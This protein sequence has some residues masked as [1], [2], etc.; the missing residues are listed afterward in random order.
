M[1]RSRRR[2][3]A[4]GLGLLA[5]VA[6]SAQAQVVISQVYGGG[7]NSNAAYRADYIEL[8]NVTSS[9]QSVAGWS[10]QYASASGTSWQVTPLSGTI[11]AGGYLLV[12]QFDNTATN[13]GAPVAVFDVAGS[14]NM[15]GTSG[16]VAL[17]NSTAPLSGA[18]P[19]GRADLV[20]FGTTTCFEG[21]GAAPSPASNAQAVKRVDDCVDT[22][23][24]STDFSAAP[25][26]P[27]SSAS[28]ISSC[29]GPV[30]PSLS[31]TDAS[32]TEGDAGTTLATFTIAL[33]APAGAGGV[34]FDWSTADGTAT[35]ADGDYLATGGSLVIPAGADRVDVQVAISGDT[36]SEPNE[37]FFVNVVN[38][39]GATVID[40]QGAGTIVNDDFVVLPIGQV[41]GAGA[42]S[43]YAGQ[44]VAVRGIV[45]GRT[46]RGFFLQSRD[47]DAD[48]DPT[49]S[50]GAY[51]F[52]NAAPPAIAQPGRWLTVEATVQEYVPSTDPGQAPLTE[53]VNATSIL[54]VDGVT[55][56][57]PAPVDL[58]PSFPSP[59]GALD[60]LERLEG[61]R[62][63]VPD[64]VATAPSDGFKTESSAT[65]STN[66]QFFGTVYGVARP[67]REPGIQAPDAPPAGTVPPIPRWDS[68][69]EVFSVDSDGLVNTPAIDVASGARIADMTGPLTF[70]FGRYQILPDSMGAVTPG[71]APR[72]AQ[73]APAG[74]FSVAGYNMERFYD[75]VD[76]PGVSDVRLTAAAVERRLSKASLGVRDFLRTPDI[77]AVVEMENLSVLQRVADRV[78]ADATAAGA[79]NPQYVPY[80]VE[81]NDVGGIDVGFLVKTAPVAPGTPRVEVVDVQQVGK[82][83]TW[84]S[85]DGQTQL[86]ND[87]PPLLLRA[88]VRYADG[89]A[90]PVEVVAVHQRS[91]NGA[92]TADAAGDRIRA[93]RQRQAEF[94][95]AFLDARQ[96]SAP[97]TRMVVLGDFN[98]FEFNDGLAHIMG[99]VTGAPAADAETA[100]AGDGADL[101]EPNFVNLTTTEP[102]DE[103]YSFTFDGNAQTLDHVLVNEAMVV[104]TRVIKADHARINA[105]FP[106]TN[107]N[108]ASSPSRLADHD[109]V[110]AYFVPRRIAD[111][112][113]SAQAAPVVGGQPL[114]FD[115]RLRDAG[116]DQADRPGIGFDL[117]AELPGLAIAAPAGWTCTPNAVAAGRTTATCT[118]DALAAGAEAVFTLTTD[119]SS[120]L[121]GR[122]LVLVAAASGTSF[123]PDPSDDAGSA[124]IAITASADLGVTAGGVPVL[125]TTL[126]QTASIGVTNYGADTAIAPRLL[127]TG[128]LPPA[129]VAMTPPAGWTCSIVAI[130]P[131]FR[132]TCDAALLAR[133][134]AAVLALRL[135]PVLQRTA[136]TLVI[137]ARVEAAT[138]DPRADNDRAV[139]TARIMGPVR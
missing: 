103:R 69:P 128:N 31:I 111:L 51:V 57:L 118:A 89:R 97:D 14:I 91:L 55:Y 75:E 120:G 20:G 46:S 77:L 42:V 82:D 62:V 29:T 84:L 32:A 63:R 34:A 134:P 99:T 65:S 64:F 68:N 56:P 44:V 96:K 36:R 72:A 106:E 101:V 24:N 54:A 12:R 85:P 70:A 35:V 102:R 76:D 8:H 66:G 11:P 104:A 39:T 116:P 95:A 40:G 13:V 137:D 67:F 110:I 115:V 114:R 30:M 133:G 23:A 88:V 138:L 107:R 9:P 94:L 135:G 26:L 119:A 124:Q 28:P 38:V 87:R 50:E 37:T 112:E 83:T 92:E 127:V 139:L 74:A 22:D 3:A 80:L 53:L 122:P 129:A 15:S 41:Q 123:D 16:K 136:D 49:T 33:T 130:G 25:A 73:A 5:L 1:H 71:A 86:L 100:V 98:A 125:F 132:I 59:A 121:R 78:N 109:P 58:T 7:G 113:V 2:L 117:D 17:V 27:R 79:A 93:K 52:L 19:A 45:T 61:M 43:P 126:R 105:D 48:A 81:G 47:V 6:G 131:G 108:D 18:C 90:F 4:F 60:Q 21:A 10:V